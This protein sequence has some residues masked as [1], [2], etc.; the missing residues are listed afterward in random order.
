VTKHDEAR[1]DRDAHERQQDHADTAAREES[2]RVAQ[3]GPDGGPASGEAPV[4]PHTEMFPHQ[5]HGQ[6]GQPANR[7]AHEGHQGVTPLQPEDQ[8]LRHGVSPT[9]AVTHG[10][11]NETVPTEYARH[12]S[13]TGKGAENAKEAK[14]SKRGENKH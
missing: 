7:P 6:A 8:D 4:G 9:E 14:D 11:P 2:A 5:P 1:D 10:E 13:H 3:L 12:K